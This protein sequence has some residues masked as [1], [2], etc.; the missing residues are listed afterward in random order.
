MSC[1][2]NRSPDFV[3][4]TA[5]S[6]PRARIG[7]SK[8]GR[9]SSRSDGSANLGLG[10]RHVR[11][12]EG[13]YLCG[14]QP[15]GNA[16]H[17]HHLHFSSSSAFTSSSPTAEGLDATE[18]GGGGSGP[19]LPTETETGSASTR[20][21]RSQAFSLSRWWSDILPSREGE[22]SRCFFFFTQWEG[23]THRCLRRIE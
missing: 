17:I 22:E 13:H 12:G 16:H 7:I 14:V 6:V 8:T 18:S 4:T 11:E 5:R 3:D 2:S 9:V 23:R 15:D 19:D 20:G 1:R 10:D 21:R